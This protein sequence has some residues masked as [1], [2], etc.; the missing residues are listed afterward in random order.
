[1]ALEILGMVGTNES[2]EIKGSRETAN[3]VDTAYLTRFAQAHE[4]AG[5]DRVLIGYGATWVD[6]WSVASH[7]LHVTSSLKVLLAHRPGF[8]Q[9]TLAA[10]SAATLDNLSG[11]GRFGMHFITGGDETDQHR[12]GD[13]VDHDKRYARTAEYMG[14]IR[15]VLDSGDPF[16]HEGQSYRY[17]GAYSAV[18]PVGDAKIPFYFGGASGPAIEAGAANADVYMLWGEPLAGIAERIA[19]IREVARRYGR[20]PSFSLSTRPILGDTEDAAWARARSIAETIEARVDSRA[21]GAQR[22]NTSVGGARLRAFADEGEVLDER[23]WTKVAALT[24][25][26]YNATALVGTGEQVAEALLR[27]YDLGVTHFL[28]RGFDPY[29]DAIEYGET[30]IPALRAG[31]E[32]R[33]ATK[34]L[35]TP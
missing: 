17:E 15:R 14:I 34:V 7:V 33:A 30:L 18:H 2:S 10:R 35:V 24:G 28:I 22:N 3:A 16:D 29:E 9:P 11:G 4:T 31:V 6:G 23:L 5:F 25:G 13:F 26:G 12:D 32:T 20:E 27:Y 8:M 19:A 21:W 1:M